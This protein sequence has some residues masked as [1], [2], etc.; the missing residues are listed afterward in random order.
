VREYAEYLIAEA[1][2]S[3][4]AAN[5]TAV[6]FR[7]VARYI[8]GGNKPKEA[9]AMTAP[10]RTSVGEKMAMTAPVRTAS[11]GP[12]AK[13]S[14]VV[15]SKYSLRSAP[16]P[17]DR[18]VR[19]KRLPRHYLAARS[20]SGPPPKEQRIGD[21]KRRLIDALGAA[22]LQP[23]KD[24]VEL[25]YGYHDPFLTPNLLRKNEVAV[26]VDPASIANVMRRKQ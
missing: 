20:F 9:M 16:T 11:S 5:P 6:G 4:T 18:S 12:C 14:F 24:G 13:V 8:F 17:L 7:T 22:G 1:E 10:V 25:V 2:V 19:L 23:A 15:P 21:E 3:A 26:Y